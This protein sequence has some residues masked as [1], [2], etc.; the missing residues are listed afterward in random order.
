MSERR[1][2]PVAELAVGTLVLAV[3]SAIVIAGNVPHDPPFALVI[4]LLGGSGLLLAAAVLLLARTRDFAWRPFFLV[5][6]WSL[7]G[8]IVIAGM[9]ELVFIR[10]HTPGPQLTA[11]SVMLALFAVDVPLLLGFSVARY[12]RAAGD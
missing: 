6:R 11:M 9:I 1:L 3:I 12:Q 5:A 4:A 10:N 8:Y 2:P 7:V